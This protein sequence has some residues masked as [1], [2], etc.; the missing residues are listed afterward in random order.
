MSAMHEALARQVAEAERV[1]RLEARKAIEAA[2]EILEWR[3]DS[4]PQFWRVVRLAQ[5]LIEHDRKRPADDDLFAPRR[6]A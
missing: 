6:S 5:A 3:L 4:A 2:T 1:P